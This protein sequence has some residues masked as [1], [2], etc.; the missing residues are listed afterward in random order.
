M[1]LLY[2]NIS[3][4][5]K[6]AKFSISIFIVML[7]FSFIGYHIMKLNILKNAQN[8]G[9]NLART[10][11]LEQQSNFDFYSVLLSFG[12][13]I[14]DN[15]SKED[16][17]DKMMNFFHQVQSLLG[18]GTVDPYLVTDKNI[19]ALNPWDGDDTYDFSNAIW[20]R[21]ASEN[22]GKVIF[23]DTYMDAIYKKPVITIAKKCA[24]GAVLAFDI[25]PEN[26]RFSN[27]VLGRDRKISFFLCDKQGT[28]L[29]V[30][31]EVSHPKDIVQNYVKILFHRIK[32][33]ELA[34]YT[35]SIV[36]MEGQ[37]RGV[38]Y[39]EMPNGWISILTIPFSLILK[40]LNA[41]S[42]I[43]SSLVALLL[44]GMA[45]LTWRN[46][47]N[48]RKI[49]RTNEAVQVLGNRYYAVYRVDYGLERY[50]TIK[51]SSS[52]Q[53]DLA[54]SGP[55]GELM[56]A[57]CEELETSYIAE[58]LDKFSL[59]NI[60]AL[61]EHR[62]CDFGGDFRQRFG[63]QFRWV[64]IR[65]LYDE[66][67]ASKE[68]ILSFREIEKEK[69]K[70]LDEYTLLVN[71]LNKAQQSDKA[72]QTFFSSVSHEMRTP[73]NAI[74]NLT[75]IAKNV[76][77]NPA[78]TVGYLEKIETS[79]LHLIRLVNDI[80][81]MSRLTQ[82]KAELSN[83]RLNIRTCLEEIFSP[84]KIQAELEG[85]IFEV[86]WKINHELIMGDSF[87]ITQIF[88]NLLSNAL[89]FTDAGDSI[90]IEVS[91]M[92]TQGNRNEY[93][94]Y[95]IVVSDT[96]I[97]M[98]E[99]FLKKI[100][101]PYSREVHPFARQVS[102]TGLGMPIMKSVIDLMNGSVLV[103]SKPGMGSSFTVILPFLLV[104]DETELAQMSS[105]DEHSEDYLKEKHLLIVEDNEINM[106]VAEEILMLKGL[107]VEKAWSGREALESFRQSDLFHFDAVLMDMQ[108]PEMDGCEACRRI[109]A[110][111]RPDASLVPVIAV[112]A[113][114]F[115]EDIA[116][117]DKAGMNAHVSKPINF[118]QPCR[119]LEKHI[120][121]YHLQQ[122]TSR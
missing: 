45:L 63:D 30:Q 10:Y 47:C 111:P 73:L 95:K 26:L 40:D 34:G 80:L 75:S 115:A 43:F 49:E 14:V 89:K 108:M 85:K 101:E 93:I 86:H 58:Y 121:Q 90:F 81:E 119:I 116:E 120:R 50:E 103:T 48:Q 4:M 67:L 97:G 53:R 13:N 21:Q 32:K 122:K 28:L 114:A 87:R 15:S 27:V 29:Y 38:Y 113:N 5:T 8:F 84:F 106:E 7:I 69:Q 20:Y 102:G 74:I 22:P 64:S 118:D 88:N 72:R 2:K 52:L 59:S 98:S 39:Y 94:Q 25:F 77:G 109:R 110:L 19:I 51:C 9:D 41:F 36:D 105:D 54:P 96:G 76:D 99:E 117:T 12:V 6:K 92:N 46:I 91:Q 3:Y 78:R 56:K 79:S 31:T 100:F 57:V 70:Q 68:V 24:S 33:N 17:S 1:K 107:I 112:T 60:R 35:T 37:R 42:W 16:I 23:T 104:R 65:V 11:S 62:I 66:S 83:T 82:G 18:E 55:Y 44:V 71:S 61:V